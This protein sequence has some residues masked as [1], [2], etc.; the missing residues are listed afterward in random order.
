MLRLVKAAA[1]SSA[2]TWS[3]VGT[4]GGRSAKCGVRNNI[5]GRPDSKRASA[6]TGLRRDKDAFIIDV[7]LKAETHGVNAVSQSWFKPGAYQKMSTLPPG[8]IDTLL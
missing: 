6:F 7:I 5:V 2:M 4:D 8:L 1:R 3:T